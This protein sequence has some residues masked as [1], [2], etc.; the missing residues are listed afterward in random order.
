MRMPPLLI[1]GPQGVHAGVWRVQRARVKRKWMSVAP[2]PSETKPVGAQFT[3]K[4]SHQEMR[5]ESK[6]VSTL[7]VDTSLSGVLCLSVPQIAEWF[8]LVTF[9][10]QRRESLNKKLNH[11]TI[12]VLC[13]TYFRRN[14]IAIGS[15]GFVTRIIIA[16]R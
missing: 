14:P 1:N 7:T 4:S 8:P 16:S 9:D 12:V 2:L 10:T 6:I 5:K 3:A 13:R 11:T 15:T